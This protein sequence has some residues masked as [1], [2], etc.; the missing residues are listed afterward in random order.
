V[1]NSLKVIKFKSQKDINKAR[2]EK[3]D[4]RKADLRRKVDAI[5]S[6]HNQGSGRAKVHS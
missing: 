2:Q 6:T 4:Q 1:A 3:L 5:K